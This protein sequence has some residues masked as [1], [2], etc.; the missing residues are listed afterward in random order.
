M[1][2]RSQARTAEDTLRTT[3]QSGFMARFL[4]AVAGVGALWLSIYLREVNPG[5]TLLVGGVGVLLTAYT[6]TRKHG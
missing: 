5:V 6:L 2:Q 3:L 4:P 1:E